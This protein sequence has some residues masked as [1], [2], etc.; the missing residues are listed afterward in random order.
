MLHASFS[1]EGEGRGGKALEE[2]V[3]RV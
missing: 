1:R 2:A 3:S